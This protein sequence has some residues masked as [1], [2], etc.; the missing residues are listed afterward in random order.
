MKILI[1]LCLF[2]SS[3][4]F[5]MK[6]DILLQSWSTKIHP[7]FERMTEGELKNTQGMSLFY[8]YKLMPKAKRNLILVPGRT[9]AALKYAELIYDLKDSGFN[10]FIMDHQGQGKSDRILADSSKSHVKVFQHYVQ[11]FAQFM[12]EVVIPNSKGEN[13][14]IAHSMGAA[15]TTHYMNQ[16]PKI[17]AKAVLLAPMY[18]I[19]T[20][21]YSEII[22]LIYSKLLILTNKGDD[23]APGKGPYSAEE[24][25]FETNPYTHSRS[26]FEVDKNISIQWPKLALGGPTAN[27]VNQAILATRSIDKLTVETPILMFQAG[28]DPIVKLPRQNSFCK[29]HKCTMKVYPTAHHEIIMESDGIRDSAM[30][31]IK[32]FFGF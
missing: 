14:I 18:E 17:I 8:R 10:I 20:Q 26:R 2:S 32:S 29:S 9:E 6:E 4:S 28:S 23:Y 24:D 27:W 7:Y 12:N 11:D 30:L 1:L 16:N 3:L 19:D 13:F 21:K 22:A 25:V 15:I 5:A 31:E